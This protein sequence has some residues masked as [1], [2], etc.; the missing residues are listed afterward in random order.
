MI[1]EIAERESCIIVG[2]CADY[3][4][5]DRKNVLKVFVY[6]DMDD[7]VARAVKYYGMDE[8][9]ARKEIQ[10]IDKLRGNHYNYYTG[11]EWRDYSNYDIC[12]NSDVLGVED[13]ADMIAKAVAKVN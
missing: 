9:K 1:K 12:I 8:K 3:I 10:R 6:S 11:N 4:L 5:R 7:K 13:A 2:R